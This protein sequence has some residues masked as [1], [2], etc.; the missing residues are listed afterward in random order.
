M[1]ELLLAFSFLTLASCEEV[2]ETGNKLSTPTH[3]HTHAGAET[4]RHVGEQSGR[5]WGWRV[6]ITAPYGE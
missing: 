3:T 4:L 2:N 6:V 1:L 5:V